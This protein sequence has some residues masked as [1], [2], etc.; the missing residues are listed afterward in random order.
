MLKKIPS[1]LGKLSVGQKLT[2][3]YLL[4]LTAVIYV[5]S[6][7][8]QEK[9]LAIDFARKEM[10]GAHYTDAVRSNLLQVFIDASPAAQPDALAALQQAREQSDTALR[11]GELAGRFVQVLA[12]TPPRTEAEKV[13]TLSLGRDLLTT[14]GNQSNLILDPDLDSYYVM[15]LSN[16]RFPELLQV[17]HES[18]QFMQSRSRQP[19]SQAQAAQLL[20]LLGRLDAVLQGLESDYQQVWL[21]GTPALQ[22]A[23]QDTRDALLKHSRLFE[24]ALKGAAES[25]GH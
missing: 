3:I 2:L 11:T 20:T 7:L 6:I 8:I 9:Y 15:S 5:S 17:L 22:A 4:D 16:L 24:S 25:E 18:H 19:A 14:V 23:L 13:K 1:W 21:A 10:V 12:S